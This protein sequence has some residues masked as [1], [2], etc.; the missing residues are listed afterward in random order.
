ML[1]SQS[2][3]ACSA[4]TRAMKIRGEA[5]AFALWRAA[6]AVDWDCTIPEVAR[7]VGIS[8]GRAREIARRKGWTHR[9]ST[10]ALNA[11]RAVN[12]RQAH[13]ALRGDAG[14]ADLDVCALMGV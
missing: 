3:A 1:D 14:A 4:G 5:S 11:T 10:E 6:Q 2:S 12:A 8:A 7:E 9:F 13:A